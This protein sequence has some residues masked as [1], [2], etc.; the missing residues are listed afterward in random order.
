M[1]TPVQPDNEPDRETTAPT[2]GQHAAPRPYPPA[3][4]AATGDDRPA[5]AAASAP[6]EGG[7]APV[8]PP[9]APAPPASDPPAQPTAPPGSIPAPET[10]PPP[11]DRREARRTTRREVPEPPSRPGVVRHVLGVLLGLVLTPVAVLLVGIGTARLS[12]AAGTGTD[13]DVLG[14]TLLVVGAVLLLAVV[15]LG[16]WS[17]AVP[18][19]G[20]LVWGVALGVAYLVVPGTMESVVDQLS[21]GRSVPAAVDE[22][23]AGAMSG[24]LL[25]TGLLL[26]G[27][28]LATA[29]ARRAGRRWA[30]AVAT[31]HA[32]RSEQ[33]RLDTTAGDPTG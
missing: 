27:A 5:P 26:L 3:P 21:D 18:I 11:A 7:S 16:V 28:G 4:P 8:A 12:D 9:T 15:L 31:A 24:Q 17:P 6:P 23:A 1:S 29:F 22:L 14:A 30:Q 10:S 33:A 20:G 32:A 25:V 13:T 19:T 2:T